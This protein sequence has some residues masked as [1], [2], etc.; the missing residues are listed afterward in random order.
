MTDHNGSGLVS[1]DMGQGEKQGIMSRLQNSGCGKMFYRRFS[2]TLILLAGLASGLLVGGCDS[3]STES[4]TKSC[5]TYQIKDGDLYWWCGG[6]C[7]TWEYQREATAEDY[8]KYCEVSQLSRSPARAL[9]AEQ[10]VASAQH[11]EISVRGG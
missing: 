2:L 10:K 11:L 6:E 8:Q 1:E 4:G 7:S 3:G 9:P 5:S